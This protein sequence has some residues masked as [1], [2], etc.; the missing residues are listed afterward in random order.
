[1]LLSVTPFVQRLPRPQPLIVLRCRVNVVVRKIRVSEY[2]VGARD[3]CPNGV[4][5]VDITLDNL[6]A[7]S[8]ERLRV[9]LRR[10][11]RDASNPP[12]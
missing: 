8:F 1:M 2:T 5:V 11:T 9:R 12:A 4:D 6:N 10:V 7:L 3:S